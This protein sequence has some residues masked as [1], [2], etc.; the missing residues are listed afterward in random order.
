MNKMP[1]N[2]FLS[3]KSSRKRIEKALKQA[4]ETCEKLR[5]SAKVDLKSMHE[6]F[7]I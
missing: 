4:S 2:G 1:K 6:R 7:D 3:S 5:K